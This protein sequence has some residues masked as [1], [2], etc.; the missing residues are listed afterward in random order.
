MPCQEEQELWCIFRGDTVPYSFLFQDADSND[1][2]IPLF[3]KELWFT[4]K[5][6]KNQ[7]DTEAG[8]QK[9]V[10]FPDDADS[11]AGVGYM[12]LLPE[13]TDPLEIKTYF[14]DFQLVDTTVD[15]ADVTTLGSG[16]VAVKQDMTVSIT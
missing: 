12:K 8:L 11:A 2:P 4:M 7:L 13:D 5:R 10:V 6:K 3:G 9:K 14:Y 16:T 1:E 15:P